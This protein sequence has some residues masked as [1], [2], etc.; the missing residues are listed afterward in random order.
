M[1]QCRL[2]L[3]SLAT[4][5]M[6]TLA[7]AENTHLDGVLKA[8]ESYAEGQREV[9]KVPGMAIAIVKDDK[10]V[11]AHG[12]GQRGLHDSR[13][14]DDRTIFQIGSLSKGFTSALVAI[15]V[16]KG[17]FGWNDRVIDHLPTFRVYDP[18][19]TAE[20]QLVDLMAQR[21]GLPS[22]AGD[23][24]AFMGF[25]EDDLMDHLRY[26]KPVTSFRASYAY[27]NVFFLAAARV[28][29]AKSGSS[30]ESL[31]RKELFGP[32]EM[33][34][35]S[36]SLEG[37]LNSSNRAEWL[38]RLADG[39]TAQLGENF[40]YRNWNYILGPAGG[41][42]SNAR[43]MANWLILQTNEGRFANKQLISPQNMR[44]LVRPEIFVG[45]IAGRSLY[46][47]LGW[48][49]M[50]YSPHPIIWHD[51][52]TLG[53]YNVAAFIPQE[54]LGI[55]VLTNVRNTQLALALAMRFF[56]LYYDNQDQAW[57]AA[58][59]PAIHANQ[60][61]ESA[62]TSPSPAQPLDAYA[63]TYH[64]PIYGEATVSVENGR[65]VL[66]MGKKPERFTLEHYDR[67]IFSFH[68]AYVEDRIT[69][70]FFLPNDSG[71]VGHLYI[72]LLANEGGG[73][74]ERKK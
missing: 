4:V 12:Y 60:P 31:L 5:A 73:T 6:S 61:E 2:L 16:D 53:V 45:E 35:S 17:W 20:F 46:Y 50:E 41:I 21:S 34:D 14:V 3:L 40:P 19:A 43:E 1:K 23:S 29:Q 22:A 44:Q 52:S 27:Q 56:D 38:I 66:T 47:A 63:G 74:F 8:F 68:W 70:T 36:T 25:N 58:L 59:I 72:D 48:V 10:V 49:H 69:K 13:P 39:S 24:Q 33:K 67:D 18:W 15:G 54:K 64:N 26:L 55:V 7:Y 57:E 42:N 30:W 9:W 62:P 51:G 71:K 65:L 11:L 37:Y 28:L 32:L